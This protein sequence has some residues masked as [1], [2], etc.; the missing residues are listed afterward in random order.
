MHPYYDNG[1]IFWQKG[2]EW[3]Q[4]CLGDWNAPLYLPPVFPILGLSKGILRPGHTYLN[5]QLIELGPVRLLDP[6]EV[7]APMD[8]VL[9]SEVPKDVDILM[10]GGGVMMKWVY[11]DTGGLS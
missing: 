4:C 7:S 11:W 9:V 8:N 6:S 2:A 5:C 3:S 10:G 1:L